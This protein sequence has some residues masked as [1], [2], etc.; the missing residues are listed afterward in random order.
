MDDVVLVKAG[1]VMRCLKRVAEEYAGDPARLS[2]PT[3]QDAMVLNLERAC[4]AAIDAANR[5][6]A[7]RHLGPP[8]SAGDAFLNLA[9]AGLV[10]ADVAERM[11][12]MVGFRNT[13][14]H[15]YQ[16]LDLAILQRI[17]ESRG[18]DLAAFFQ[19]LGIRLAP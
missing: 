8:R 4:Q 6:V 2:N 14:I 10:S 17:V 9:T 15:E 7:E 19:A 3:H 11:K 18:A 5:V 16:K 12:A 1:I 13:V